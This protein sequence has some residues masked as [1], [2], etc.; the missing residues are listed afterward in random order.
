[1]P[2]TIIVYFQIWKFKNQFNILFT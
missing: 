1:M 2:V